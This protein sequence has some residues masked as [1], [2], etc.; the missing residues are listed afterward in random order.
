MNNIESLG[1]YV[2]YLGATDLKL[3]YLAMFLISGAGAVAVSFL[4]ETLGATLPET[5][6]EASAF[7]KNDKYFS[8]RPQSLARVDTEKVDPEEKETLFDW[9][10][11]MRDA[12]Q[13]KPGDDLNA[14][15]IKSLLVKYYSN[16][17]EQKL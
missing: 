5:L 14:T 12:F 13:G 11:I 3:P 4:P 2:I 1:P 7:G 8:W 17:P 10:P 6:D 9:N 16:L 15:L